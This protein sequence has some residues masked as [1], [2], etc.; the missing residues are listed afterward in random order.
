MV[1][2]PY[3]NVHSMQQTDRDCNGYTIAIGKQFK[4][5]LAGLR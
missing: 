4:P 2:R 3:N 1:G 5:R